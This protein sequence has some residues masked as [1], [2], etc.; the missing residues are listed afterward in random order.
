MLGKSSKC[1]RVSGPFAL[2]LLASLMAL[3][4]DPISLYIS[5]IA[6]VVLSVVETLTVSMGII[7]LLVLM[8]IFIYSDVGIEF[9]LAFAA[10]L[11]AIGF[12]THKTLF[13][14]KTLSVV[15]S[16]LS[17]SNQIKELQTALHDRIDQLNIA[18][19]QSHQYNLY[20]A[21]LLTQ[22]SRKTATITKL[23]DILNKKKLTINHMVKKFSDEKLSLSQHIYD[24]KQQVNL[25]K[26]RPK[27][28]EQLIE[29]KKEWLSIKEGLVATNQ[30]L[31]SKIA[32]TENN[33]VALKDLI[34]SLREEKQSLVKK[35]NLLALDNKAKEKIVENALLKAKKL[36]EI[37]PKFYVLRD[38]FKMKKEII[39]NASK[40]VF[41][42]EEELFLIKRKL[43]NYTQDKVSLV[44]VESLIDEI[45]RLATENGLLQDLVNR[46]MDLEK[47][48]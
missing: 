18:R 29:A 36:Q 33:M 31:Q 28:Y 1:L 42:L 6:L 27:G 5:I 26:Q 35:N 44:C 23:E 48:L 37:E 19:C 24:L 45:D 30:T 2:M 32:D 40:K 38:Q 9:S 47:N 21:L 20:S 14:T 15:P 25:L 17:S 34:K 8:R 4:N 43:K 13:A 3:G 12:I 7:Y 41:S 16:E 46:V 10:T 11:T 39:H 22:L